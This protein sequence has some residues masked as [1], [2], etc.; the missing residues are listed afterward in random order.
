MLGGKT[1]LKARD[2]FFAFAPDAQLKPVRKRIHNRNT[3]T[4]QAARYLVGVAVKLTARVQLGHDDLGCGN[5]FFLVD[6]DGNTAPVIT[7]GDGAVVV[8]CDVHRIRMTGQ[9]L[10][11]AVVHDLIDHVVQTRPII[12]ITDVHARTFAN[13]F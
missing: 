5:A 2:M 11:D 6:A 7:D 13:S 8:D 4:V 9:R 3:H 12:G 1:A 10:V